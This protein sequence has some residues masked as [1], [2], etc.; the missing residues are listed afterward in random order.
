MSAKEAK[1][2]TAKAKNKSKEKLFGP[3][4]EKVTVNIGVG[5]AGERLKKAETV[6]QNI[7]G[8]KPIQTLS[9]TTSKDWGLRKRMPI[10]C[11]VTLR[12]NAAEN[13]LKEAL[14][15]R[16]NKMAEYS[17]DG[18]GNLSFGIPDHTLFKD[19]R[20]DPDIGIFGMDVCIT[21]EKP[22]H[23]IKRRRQ[24]RRKVPHRQRVQ[25][26]ETMEFFTKAFSVEVI[27]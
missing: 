16:E 10:G 23:R 2:A 14:A 15:T 5:E 25:R 8:H 20:Y 4:I 21:M 12:R 1:T 19:Q 11:K 27:Q 6:I 3:K 18:E 13:F 17:F 7:T 24:L 26:E 9:R 22:G